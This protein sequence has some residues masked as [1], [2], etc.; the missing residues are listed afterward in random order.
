MIPRTLLSLALAALLFG[1]LPASL[2]SAPLTEEEVLAL[3]KKGRALQEASEYA[4][5]EK[6]YKQ[7]L[8]EVLR[9]HG[10][11]SIPHGVVLS[12][13]ASLYRDTARYDMA[14]SL[15]KRNLEIAESKAGPNEPHTATALHRLAGVYQDLGEYEQA[16]PLFE[17]SLEI[18]EAKLGKDHVATGISL[19]N[20]ASLFQL[21]GRY[22]QAEPMYQRSLEIF[23]VKRGK[24]QPETAAV[25]HNLASLYRVTARFEL[26]EPLYKRSLEI[27]EGKLGKDHPETAKTLNN[28][29]LL[30]RDMGRYEQAEPMYQRS[31]DIAEAKRGKDHP[32]TAIAIGNLAALYRDLHKYEQ[33][34]PLY[35]RSLD[36]FQA[37]YGKDHPDTA[38]AVGNLAALYWDLRRYKEAEP[39]MTRTLEIRETKL[40]K[41][42]PDTAI[43]L[44]NLAALYR[45][46]E[47]YEEAESLFKRS[48]E[49]KEKRLG[50]DHPSI[51]L[52]LHNLAN[53]YWATGRPNLAATTLDR[54]RRVIHRHVTRVLPA[55]GQREQHDYLGRTDDPHLHFALSLALSRP[56][57][58]DLMPLSATWWLNA[59]GLDEQARAQAS[60]AARDGRNPRLAQ[61]LRD[62]L[63]LRR[64]LAQLSQ[65]GPKPGQEVD[66]LKRLAD[67]GEQEQKLT[68]RLQQQGAAV[69]VPIWTELKQVQAA[70]PAGSVFID[71]ARFRAY[72]PTERK[73]Q[74]A[75]YVAW[76]TP[77]DGPTRLVDLGDAKTIDATVVQ[78]SKA[79]ENAG[80]TL[81]TEGEIKAEKAV[82]EPLARLA[83]LILE[84]LRPHLDKASRWVIS[85]D[86]TLWVAPWAALPLDEKTYAVEKHSIQLVVSGRDLLP[87]VP[88]PG[89][90]AAPAIFADP[91]FDT[92]AGPVR[93]ELRG[94][95]SE[96]QVGRIP[97]LPGTAIEAD[98]IADKMGRVFG[99]APVVFTEGKASSSAFLALNRPRALTVATHGFFLADQQL[100]PRDRDRL[101]RDPNARISKF[102]EDPLLRCGLLLAGCNKPGDAGR[103]GVLTGREV[104]SA[105][106]R[107]CE[108]VILSACETGR[109]DIRPSEGVAGLRQA[110]Q[111]AGA[112]SVL[113]SLW[114]IP[115]DET[116]LQMVA[117]MDALAKGGD[118]VE[119]L[120][121]AQRQRISQR[122]EKFGAAH[123]FNW[124]AFTLTGSAGR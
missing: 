93:S 71:F 46:M 97:R 109:G 69:A 25:L 43:A 102:I 67:L 103:S 119:A 124:A 95:S 105:D 15:F 11:G 41:D 89:Q 107:G 45:E 10:E 98:A 40:G 53:L 101:L 113:S 3:L 26:A 6:L 47:R 32:D 77:K 76:I 63:A 117:F 42:H 83:K 72:N 19:N 94:V 38:I 21:M 48:L 18:R 57:A 24:D 2:G 106:L 58:G 1:A 66:Y 99:T 7:A 31:L 54:S 88:V 20:L 68:T 29:A 16:R 108:L 110:F 30:Y 39:L 44:A 121:V 37:R 112:E 111:L 14:L 116:T 49:I 35:K 13:L 78:V 84:P 64:Q 123:P 74:P 28:L 5:A 52:D 61:G 81:K 104:L 59:K 55:L 50:P 62:L 82:R 33:A 120:A 80:K 23:Q 85:P 8:P 118:R 87:R 90:P 27:R 122:R 96:L 60:L 100:D 4:A 9:L 34:E 12:D 22:E 36:I 75:H 86:G 73:E 115:D 65:Q 92:A 70:L 56:E 17:R 114:R 91:D 51:A 79:L